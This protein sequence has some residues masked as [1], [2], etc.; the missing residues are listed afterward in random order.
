MSIRKAEMPTRQKRH[1]NLAD[2]REFVESG[3]DCAEVD[4]N[5]R[6]SHSVYTGL[7]D[8][9]RM[10]GI[11]GVYVMKRGEHV[12]LIRDYSTDLIGEGA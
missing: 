6:K 4:L 1:S 9:V 3:W 11:A 8:C 7:R 12:Y 2:I 10:R 5:G